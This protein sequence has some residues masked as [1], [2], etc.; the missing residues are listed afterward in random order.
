MSSSL[1]ISFWNRENWVRRERVQRRGSP[2]FPPALAE[3]SRKTQ[4]PSFWGLAKADSRYPVQ[5]G[6]SP[7]P[8]PHPQVTKPSAKQAEPARRSRTE[9][10]HPKSPEK[11][12]EGDRRPQRP[13]APAKTSARPPERKAQIERPLESRCTGL[14]QPLGGWQ[15]QEE[16]S[17]PQSPSGHPEKSWGSQEEG[18]GLGGWPELGSPSLEGIWRGPP[19]EHR[20]RWGQSE[21]WEQPP[22]NGLQGGPPRG[23][24]ELCRPHQPT[25]PPDN[26]WAGP[27][28]CVCARQPEGTAAMGW[29][30]EGASSHQYSPEKAPDLDWRDLLGLL[31]AP[32]DGA[33]TRLPRLDWE[34]LLELL[35][36]RLPQ[37]DP[38]G[39]WRDPARASGPELGS[40]GTEDTLKTEPQTQPEG[41]AKATQANGH[42]LEQQ[43]ESPAQPPSPVCTSTQWPTAK[44][45]SGPETSTL[46]ALEQTAH[47]GSHSPPDLGVS[48][49]HISRVSSKGYPAKGVHCSKLCA[50]RPLTASGSGV[51][52]SQAVC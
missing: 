30:A 32:E 17:G 29:R 16:L 4:P 45:T 3:A 9:P 11:R 24:Q 15:S 52:R 25:T 28:E 33:W 37:K 47:L 2:G 6:A 12:P 1:Q 38:A 23:L 46:A 48:L 21:A 5:S 8:S 18:P 22:S 49:S 10:P 51:T 41:W 14:R 19:Q 50:P 31:R 34:G 20:E 26:S 39:H 42:S 40:P 44:V 36:T 13:S 35:Q 27:A 43:S 7:T